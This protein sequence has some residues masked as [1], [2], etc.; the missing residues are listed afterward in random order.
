[1]MYTF[2]TTT[3]NDIKGLK[4]L[5][6]S[7]SVSSIL[8]NEIIIIDSESD[9]GT[10]NYIKELQNNAKLDIVYVR[11]KLTIGSARNYGV[12]IA[13]SKYVLVSDTYCVLEKKWASLLLNKLDEGYDF[14]GGR[15]LVIGNT[16][17]QKG[18][19]KLIENR[20]KLFNPSSRSIGFKKEAFIDIGGYPKER[21]QGEDTQFNLNIIQSGK[22]YIQVP[23]AFVS[24][25]GRD[26][27]RSLYEQYKRYGIG[28]FQHKI[29]KKK[30]LIVPFL[31]PI[32]NILFLF[33]PSLVYLY[34]VLL[35][36][37]LSKK[38]NLCALKARIVIDYGAVAAVSH[39][40]LKRLTPE[41]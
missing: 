20:S 12:S 13:K 4:I 6:D 23:E 16:C 30:F 25:Y 7:L 14:V 9:D 3:Y 27:F 35:K 34:F 1:M 22:K 17:A 31:H 33:T 40:I 39:Y 28:D 11:K 18:Y 5:M 21:N 8:P 41:R 29:F 10:E 26:T 19:G 24:W 15:Y 32:T 2:V 38:L 36:L 37:L